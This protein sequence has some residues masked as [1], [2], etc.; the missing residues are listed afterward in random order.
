MSRSTKVR[1]TTNLVAGAVVASLAALGISGAAQAAPTAGPSSSVHTT[2][3]TVRPRQA[4]ATA[5]NETVNLG[6][7]IE[8][9]E[10]IQIFLHA[11][12]RYTGPIDGQLD[13]DSWMALQRE[14]TAFEPDGPGTPGAYN[15][16][17]DGIVDADTITALQKM[18]TVITGYRGPIDGIVNPDLEAAF[19]RYAVTLEEDDGI[20]PPAA[21]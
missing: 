11:R 3:S 14:L 5:A 21:A 8:Q 6:L 15:G 1:R 20:H 9:A 17:I 12:Y 10:V 4:Q 16:P 7:T 13:T 2:A 18:L 19:A